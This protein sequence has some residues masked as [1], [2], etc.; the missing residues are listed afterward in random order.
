MKKYSILKTLFTTL[1]FILLMS[2]YGNAG[3]ILK[4]DSTSFPLYIKKEIASGFVLNGNKEREELLTDISKQKEELFSSS[5]SYFFGGT[6]WNFLEYKQEVIDLNIKAGPFA[7]IGNWID[8]SRVMNIDGKHRNYGL[9]VNL[10]GNY[11]SRFYYDKKN[12]TIVK[13]N[14]WAKNE[15][16]ISNSE[17]TKIDSN[18]VATTFDEQDLSNK[19]RYGFQAKAGWGYGRMNPVNHY[20]VADYLLSKYYEGRLFSEEE[21]QQVAAKIGGIKQGRDPGVSRS[22]ENEIKE[23]N[24]YLRTKLLLAAPEIPEDLWELGEFAPRFDGTRI[25][26]GPFFNYYNREPDFYYGGYIQFNK[27]KYINVK[28]NCDFSANLKYSHYKHHN[29]AALETNLGWIY[30]SGLKSQFGFGLKYIPGAVVH[31]IDDIEPVKHNFIPYL[32]YFTQLN[33]KTRVNFMFAWNIGDGEDFMK[34]GP[35]FSLSFYRSRY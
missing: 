3:G 23:L 15:V 17:G 2:G 22:S 28:W 26:L 32:E 18:L 11:E 35:E 16:F 19:F 30:Y 34:S 1:I 6:V 25:E 20:M 4:N 33:A 5:T 24:D 13:V 21:V 27:A 8:S 31:D 12:Y 9:R 10:N 29:W 14:G 7:G